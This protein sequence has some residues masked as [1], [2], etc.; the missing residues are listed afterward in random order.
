MPKGDR[1]SIYFHDSV[2]ENARKYAKEK[3]I[4]LSQA[5]ENA[6]IKEM[7]HEWGGINKYLDALDQIEQII[8][9]TKS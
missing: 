7:G 2:L 8:K 4:S 6:M 1:F 9:K 5:L 3:N